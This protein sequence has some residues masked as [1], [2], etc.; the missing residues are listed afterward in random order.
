MPATK[1][2]YTEEFKRDV[3]A[4]RASTTESQRQTASHFG[5]TTATLR[6]CQRRAQTPLGA[7][8]PVAANESP[9]QELKR[10]RRENR[11]LH[12][13]CEILKKTVGIFTE[14]PLNALR[15]FKP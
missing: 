4:Y 5:I 12:T 7:S 2:A 15:A 13:R 1:P 8:A 11:V 10:L 14:A 3:L 9:E 6:A